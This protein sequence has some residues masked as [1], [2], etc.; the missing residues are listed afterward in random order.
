M[1]RTLLVFDGDITGVGTLSGHRL[2]IGRWRQSPFGAFADVMHEAPGGHRRL[3]APSAPIADFVAATYQ[4][5]HIEVTRV[6][7][8]R[9]GDGLRVVAGDLILELDVGGRTGLGLLLRVVPRP[10]ARARWWC[11]AIDPLARWVM[12]GVRT[13][14]TAGGGRT[15]WYGATDQ[16][17]I[18]A[19]RGTLGGQDLGALA[20]VDP[21]VRFGFS[22]API[23]PSVV[24]VRTT[25]A[26]PATVNRRKAGGPRRRRRRRTQSPPRSV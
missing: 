2:V 23:T 12:H 9:D 15:E 4:F 21:P 8:E 1:D 20:D 17:R 24:D 19:L 18:A 14:G 25:I 10:L 3:L 11:T 6:S 26:I 22:S 16:H 5:D 13:R 7:A